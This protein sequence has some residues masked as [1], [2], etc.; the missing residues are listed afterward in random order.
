MN[1]KFNPKTGTM[2][3]QKRTGINVSAR[4][5]GIMVEDYDRHIQFLINYG[6]SRITHC[7]GCRA[8]D[9][10]LF[11]DRK[12]NEIANKV[13]RIGI[14]KGIDESMFDFRTY[15]IAYKNDIYKYNNNKKDNMNTNENIS[16]RY[17]NYIEERLN[18]LM[19]DFEPIN[20]AN[21][22][23]R[24]EANADFKELHVKDAPKVKGY[25]KMISIRY[26]KRVS[27]IKKMCI[28]YINTYIDS[29][30]NVAKKMVDEEGGEL[31]LI[32]GQDSLAKSMNFKKEGVSTNGQE[33]EADTLK[34]VLFLTGDKALQDKLTAI[35]K[36]IRLRAQKSESLLEWS[37]L[38]IEQSKIISNEIVFEECNKMIKDES[39]R[40]DKDKEFAEVKKQFDEQC[41]QTEELNKAMDS[42]YKKINGDISGVI[43][44]FKKEDLN[45]T[46]NANTDGFD[47]DPVVDGKTVTKSDDNKESKN[48]ILNRTGWNKE[49]ADATIASKEVLDEYEKFTKA[50]TNASNKEKN[51][52]YAI[53]SIDNMNIGKKVFPSPIDIAFAV[54][55]SKKTVSELKGAKDGDNLKSDLVDVSKLQDNTID[56]DSIIKSIV[57]DAKLFYQTLAC[58]YS[59][60]FSKINTCITD[61][62]EKANEN[63]NYVL[64]SEEFINEKYFNRY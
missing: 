37:E 7:V 33:K 14:G 39:K 20:E 18:E 59:S 32:D 13:K 43:S 25:F 64:S 8:D 56:G 21:D 50:K 47:F 26:M 44:T 10:H 5:G 48:V 17:Q 34:G 30:L 23:E 60:M 24:K 3:M 29:C 19:P 53:A 12:A 41:K 16:S 61:K 42:V 40:K 27:D 35:L 38:M 1:W 11:D 45:L 2:E 57:S 46:N 52:A 9:L 4:Q 49:Y 6:N 22:S 54:A 63:Q 55:N 31:K 15:S 36:K 28:E 58:T 62:P 51:Y